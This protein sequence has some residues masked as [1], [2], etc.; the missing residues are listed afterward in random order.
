MAKALLMQVGFG[1]H[2][3]P[4]GIYTQFKKKPKNQQKNPERNCC[5]PNKLMAATKAVYAANP[6]TLLS[7]INTACLNPYF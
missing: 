5:V 7:M 4:S 1:P 6:R 2:Y 3:H